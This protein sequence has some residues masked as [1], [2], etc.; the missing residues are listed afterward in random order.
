MSGRDQLEALRQAIEE[1]EYTV[2][3]GGSGLLEESG[4]LVMKNPDKDYDLEIKYGISPEYIYSSA[5]YNTRIDKF[6]DFYKNEMVGEELEPNEA[7]MALAAMEKAGKLQCM[8]ESN[9]YELP[10]RAGMKNVISLHGSVYKNICPHCREEYS[11]DYIRSAKKVPLCRKCNTVIRP[12]VSL[13]GEMVDSQIMTKTTEEVAKADLLLLLGT[14][15]ESHIYKNYIRYFNGRTL[16]VIRE[17]PH[18]SDEKAD[19]AVYGP[20]REVLPELGF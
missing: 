13:Y 2:A 19:I 4:Y 16:A 6:Y 18:Y 12:Q 1:S 8:V 10:R 7:Y 17:E 11:L 14:S 20:L 3:L 15:V 9:V 5:Y